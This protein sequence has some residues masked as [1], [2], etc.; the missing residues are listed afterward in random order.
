MLP[1]LSLNMINRYLL[2][3]FLYIF[4]VGNFNDGTEWVRYTYSFEPS[5]IIRGYHIIS[6]S[7]TKTTTTA[8]HRHITLRMDIFTLNLLEIENICSL[9][10]DTLKVNFARVMNNDER[11]W[12]TPD[13]LYIRIRY[14]YIKTTSAIV[15][16]LIRGNCY[17]LYTSSTDLNE[18][19]T[20]RVHHTNVYLREYIT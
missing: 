19:T 4:S 10:I 17:Q 20:N 9:H 8:K 13:V 16:K 12:G 6:S 2:I 7:L 5:T 15:T 18:S 1:T 3:S 14:I 11:L